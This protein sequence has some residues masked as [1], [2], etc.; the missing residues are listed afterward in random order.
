[1]VLRSLIISISLVFL[2]CTSKNNGITNNE[3]VIETKSSSPFALYVLHCESC[4]GLKGDKG[5]AG[6]ADLSK[7]RI[8]IAE[9]KNTILNGNEKGM[10]PFKEIIPNK[11]DIDALTN[12]IISLQKK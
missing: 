12:Y 7:S 10:M 2:S 3:E 4:H 1:M 8:S 6:A 11:K 5:V 9:I